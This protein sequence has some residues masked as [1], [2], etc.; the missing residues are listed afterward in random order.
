MPKLIVVLIAFLTVLTLSV[1]QSP[2]LLAQC[3]PDPAGPGVACPVIPPV[4]APAPAVCDMGSL[5]FT[6]PAALAWAFPA[7][8]LLPATYDVA[9]G[10]LEC[11]L[12]G[13][14]VG[15]RVS[16][17]CDFGVP[18]S[19]AIAAAGTGDAAVPALGEGYWYLVRVS[20]ASWNDP[21]PHG[22]DYDP[23]APDI[24]GCP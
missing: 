17:S 1:L 19:C 14:G 23:V 13:A 18:A 20:T 10:D 22:T 16:E 8:C 6:G 3:L 15:T 2:A 7:G 9:R 12:D 24:T 11:L 5:V 21:T 4:P